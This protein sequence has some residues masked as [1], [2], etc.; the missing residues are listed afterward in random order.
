MNYNYSPLLVKGQRAVGGGGEGAI[1]VQISHFEVGV[2]FPRLDD[3]LRF[4]KG[5]RAASCPS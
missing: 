1:G 4:Q 5:S 3:G 2:F